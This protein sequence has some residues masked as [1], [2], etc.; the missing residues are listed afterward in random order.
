MKVAK[1]EEDKYH[2][3]HHLSIYAAWSFQ[4]Y[5]KQMTNSSLMFNVTPYN[6][7]KDAY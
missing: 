3:T 2:E 7:N 6:W 4:V 5:F 1:K